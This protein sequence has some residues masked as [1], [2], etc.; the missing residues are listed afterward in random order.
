MPLLLVACVMR[1]CRQ[2]AWLCELGC[3]LLRA[4]RHSIFACKPGACTEKSIFSDTQ[5]GEIELQPTLKSVCPIGSL[6]LQH[7]YKRT[8]PTTPY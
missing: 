5:H 8:T 3:Q 4:R 2:G 1:G 7:S 6:Q